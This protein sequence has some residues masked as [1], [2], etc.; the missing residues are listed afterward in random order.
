METTNA[1]Y[2]DPFIDSED[3]GECSR[4]REEERS[5]HS[6]RQKPQSQDHG[7]SYPKRN[8]AALFEVADGKDRNP[9]QHFEEED[10]GR[11]CSNARR[12][13]REG[14]SRRPYVGKYLNHLTLISI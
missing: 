6:T 3:S 9:P 1:V 11:A 10:Y 5:N 12:S 4:N 13:H 8:D 14:S 2:I 7:D